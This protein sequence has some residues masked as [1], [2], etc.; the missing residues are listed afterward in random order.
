MKLNFDI[1]TK[2][3]LDAKTSIEYGIINGNNTIVF[4]KPGQDG[5]MYGYKNK[6]LF[7][8]KKLNKKYNCTV[9][10][11]SNSY[12]GRNPLDY[13]I[14]IIE[15]YAKVFDSY[16][17]FY[18]GFSKGATIGA[19]FGAHYPKIKRM[20]L[21]NGPLMYNYHKTKQGVLDFVGEKITFIYGSLDP[22]IKYTELLKLLIS[23]RIKLEI[24][25]GANHYFSEKEF[26]TIVEKTLFYD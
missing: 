25:L 22:S 10:C 6:Y 15:D 14:K 11:S 9:I 7:L 18:I 2:S 17:I 16:Q 24:V 26:Y 8:A 21:I 5:S 19:W 13:D 4:I 1:E 20:V 12:D 23:N 3:I